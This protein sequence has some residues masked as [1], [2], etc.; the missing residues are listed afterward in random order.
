MGDRSYCPDDDSLTTVLHELDEAKSLLYK[1][2]MELNRAF[3]A[4]SHVGSSPSGPYIFEAKARELNEAT[5]R[6]LRA[7]RSFNAAC[8]RRRNDSRQE[9]LLTSQFPVRSAMPLR[10]ERKAGGFRR[11]WSRRR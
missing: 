2:Q 4:L 1:E 3:P 5:K 8:Q 11:V 7:I 10:F 9:F 6:Y